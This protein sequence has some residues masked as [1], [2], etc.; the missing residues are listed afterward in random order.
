[1]S[2]DLR[3][4]YGEVIC[5]AFSAE[6]LSAVDSIVDCFTSPR[7]KKSKSFRYSVRLLAILILAQMNRG[8]E[9]IS[10]I[11][12]NKNSKILNH[13]ELKK[14]LG[15]SRIRHSSLVKV[16][17]NLKLLTFANKRFSIFYVLAVPRLILKYDEYDKEAYAPIERV[18][19]LQDNI[20]E[21]YFRFGNRAKEYME[22]EFINNNPKEQTQ[23]VLQ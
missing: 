3:E 6:D 10:G 17:K 19:K 22:E 13:D 5:D 4:I 12:S 23:N 14:Y 1:M 9:C 11:L 21:V 15:F 7:Y 20:R 18:K 16:V 2:A 8:V